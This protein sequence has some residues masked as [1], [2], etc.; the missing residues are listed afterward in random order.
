M[1]STY[2]RGNIW[3]IQYYRDGIAMRE[4]SGSASQAE[5]KRVL[6]LKEADIAK[7]IPVTPRMGRI[8]FNEMA[9]DLMA[10][11]KVN[12]RRSLRDLKVRLDR[13]I[14]PVFG[15]RNATAINTA[16]VNNFKVR[17]QEAG[18]SNAEI[19]RE[20][21]ALKRAFSLAIEGGKV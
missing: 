11:Y 7:G 12:C 21:A 15:D 20:L 8:K 3:W 4:S 10:D 17:R 5:A 1:G 13:H 16:D 18:A 14:L 6:S 2:K 9:A 19:N